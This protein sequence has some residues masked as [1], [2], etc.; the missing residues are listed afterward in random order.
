MI[1]DFYKIPVANIKKLVPNLFCERKIPASLWKVA[2][3]L[4]TRIRIFKKI[5]SVTMAI[6]KRMEAEKN[7][8]KMEKCC[9]N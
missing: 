1:V 5:Q 9:E 8:D 7:S 6:Q 4:K 3:L 2:T